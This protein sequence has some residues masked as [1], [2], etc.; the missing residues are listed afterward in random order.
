MLFDQ[1][2]HVAVFPQRLVDRFAVP[3]QLG[4]VPEVPRDD[5]EIEAEVRACLAV[6]E[7]VA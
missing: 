2:V 5:G 6:V 7:V 3:G 4:R 1:A